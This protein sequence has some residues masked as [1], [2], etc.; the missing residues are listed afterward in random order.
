MVLRYAVWW[1]SVVWRT[2]TFATNSCSSNWKAAIGLFDLGAGRVHVQSIEPDAVLVNYVLSSLIWGNL[3]QEAFGLRSR[4]G[5][6]LVSLVNPVKMCPFPTELWLV[7]EISWDRKS[8]PKYQ[9]VCSMHVSFGPRLRGLRTS[10]GQRPC[11]LGRPCC[12]LKHWTT[13]SCRR[14]ERCDCLVALC[15]ISKI[16]IYNILWAMRWG[17]WFTRKVT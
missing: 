12:G 4:R 2:L 10:M 7:K 3:W 16:P 15:S 6:V 17:D 11:W 14:R 8:P 9:K 13:S 1:C 5:F